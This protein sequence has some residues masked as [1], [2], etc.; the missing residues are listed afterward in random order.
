MRTRWA[1][2][3]GMLAFSVLVSGGFVVA[4]KPDAIAQAAQRVDS[5][6]PEGSLQLHE[7]SSEFVSGTFTPPKQ[8]PLSFEATRTPSR[9]SFSIRQG[10]V[11]V[12]DYRE[13]ENT[14]SL[15]SMNAKAGWTAIKPLMAKAAEAARAGSVDAAEQGRIISRAVT[16]HGDLTLFDQLTASDTGLALVSLSAALGKNGLNGQ[17]FPPLAFLHTTAMRIGTARG[18]PPPEREDHE[19]HRFML[20]D[21]CQ[22]LRGDPNND[23]CLG[24]CGPGCTC[25]TDIC[26]DCCCYDGCRSHDITCRNCTWYKPWNCLLCWSFTSFLW[27]HCGMGCQSTP[28]L[29]PNPYADYAQCGVENLTPTYFYEE[30]GYCGGMHDGSTEAYRAP[31]Q[32]S[33]ERAEYVADPDPQVGTWNVLRCFPQ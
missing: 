2:V 24:M 25:W 29:E 19:A 26:G 6:Q 18:I 32:W 8:A 10:A 27:G 31:V 9:A 7:L 11:I 30:W 21:S 33:C 4:L 23:D 16:Q 13:D 1:L 22:S 17:A 15:T 14:V 20:M 5:A 12:L 3:V 28:A